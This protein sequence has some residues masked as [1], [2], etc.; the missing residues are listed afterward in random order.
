[1]WLRFSVEFERLPLVAALF[2]DS[3]RILLYKFMIEE[4]A[5]P[6]QTHKFDR[7][8]YHANNKTVEFYRLPLN[9][10]DR[11]MGSSA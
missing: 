2:H 7:H 10:S 11:D 6:S 8:S 5:R 3:T 9:F 1:L 4:E